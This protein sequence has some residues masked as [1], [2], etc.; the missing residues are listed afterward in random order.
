[1]VLKKW[2]MILFTGISVILLA[3]GI[4][5]WILAGELTKEP[6]NKLGVKWYDEDGTVFTLTKAEELFELA[7][8]SKYYDF[9][10]QTIRLGADIVMNPGTEEDWVKELP[11]RLWEVPI[12]QF[13]GTFDGQGHSISGIYATAY[14]LAPL[15]LY[16][17]NPPDVKNWSGAFQYTP[18]ALFAYTKQSA[19]IQNLRV[20]NSLFLNHANTGCASIVSNGAGTLKNVYSNATIRSYWQNAGGLVGIV[21]RGSMHLDNCWY[22]GTIYV[23]G[24]RGSPVLRI[25]TRQAIGSSVSV[26]A[27]QFTSSTWNS[28]DTS[29]SRSPS[30][31]RLRQ[32]S[33]RIT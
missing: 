12:Y 21:E 2:M 31:T 9:A 28:C 1:M 13:A 7:K 27:I 29:D 30:T 19:V 32:A 6:N 16:Y 23:T 20:E 8:L 26:R 33:S 11:E 4:G 5:A 22:D 25:F 10:G 3:A 18:I 17:E 14:L 15:C 24:P